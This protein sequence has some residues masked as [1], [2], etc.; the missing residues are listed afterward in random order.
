MEVA[1]TNRIIRDLRYLPSSLYRKCAA[2]IQELH[3]VEPAALRQKALPGWRLHNLRGSNMTSLS[4]DMNYR[5]L[6][7]LKGDTLIL[8]RV[9]EH[10]KADRPNVNRNDQAEGIARMTAAELRPADVY[11][12]LV[13]FGV[14]SAEAEHFRTCSSEDDLWHAIANVSDATASLA[15][16]LYEVSGLA[17]PDARFRT[18]R[19]DDDFEGLVEAGGGEWELYLH[20]SQVFLVELPASYR[21]AV[22]GSAGTGKTVCAWH[23][24]KHLIDRGASVGFVCPHESTLSVSKSRLLRML[25]TEDDRSYF[26]VPKQPDDLMQLGAAVDHVIIDE[27]QEIAVTWLVELARQME[28][29]AGITL[30]YDLNQLGGNIPDGNKARYRR[31]IADWKA[32]LAMFPRMQNFRL[33]INYRN[34]REIA[35]CYLDMLSEAL[36][37]KPLADLPVFET[38][39]VLQHK[40]RGG[41]LNDVVASL[42]HRLLQDHAADEI[43]IVALERKP[44]Q[45]LSELATRTLPVAD[46]PEKGKSVV[47]TSASRIRGHERKVV[48]VTFR[49]RSA[50]R[51]NFGVAID[52]YVAMSRA[53]KR[54]ILIEVIS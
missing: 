49:G 17:I 48:I 5:M 54:L 40:V 3:A 4:V 9:V 7:E 16:A 1:I 12:A 32:M 39:D 19:E 50:L 46:D 33:T 23:R 25:G 28:D 38:G 29:G 44:R 47:V 20:P 36:P 37:S 30:F 52:A 42:L 15:L 14:S 43:G 26:C 6:T 24:T 27:A 8:H 13:S 53:I 2:L 22:V 34:A 10:D 31:R 51:R 35:E 21:L 18:L 41:E 45:L 11:G